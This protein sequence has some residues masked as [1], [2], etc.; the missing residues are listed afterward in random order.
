MKQKIQLILVIGMVLLP[1]G[2]MAQGI[3]IS[4]SKYNY[5]PIANEICKGKQSK[6]DKARAIHK[7]MCANISYDTNYSIYTADECY[8]NR[9]GVCQAY[10]ELFYRLAEAVGVK[11]TIVVGTAKDLSGEMQKS[12]HSWIYAEVEKGGILIDPT[13]GA[14]GVKNGVFEKSEDPTL[15]FDVNPYWMIFSHLPDN[16][17]YQCLEKTIDFNTFARLPGLYPECKYLGWSPKKLLTQWLNKEITSLPQLMSIEKNKILHLVNIPMQRVLDA[18]TTY[19]F[20]IENPKG[21]DFGIFANNTIYHS[22]AWHKEGNRYWIDIMPSRENELNISV[23]LGNGVYQ[24]L[25]QY[26]VGNKNLNDDT[27]LEYQIPPVIYDAG[28]DAVKL[29][30]VPKYG[31]LICGKTYHFEVDNPQHMNVAVVYNGEFFT[32]TKWQHTGSKYWID[33]PMTEPGSLTISVHREGN[34]YSDM[35]LYLVK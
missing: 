14:G 24:T 7:W 28:T 33:L 18:S 19:R 25:V 9:K 1:F 20:E 29:T 2:L 16:S 12:N 31:V 3:N 13:W 35:T 22:T 4:D 21:L 32:S 15:W 34:I 27:P 17:Q 8:E 11:C 5:A 30:N 6:I 10:S 23:N 26:P